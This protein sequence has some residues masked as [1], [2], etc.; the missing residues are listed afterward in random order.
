MKILNVNMSLDPVAGAGTAERTFQMSRYLA[1]AGMDCTILTMD[2][3]M[4]LE[5]RQSLDPVRV[6]ALPVLS[7]RF[8]IPWVR[9]G[10]VMELVGDTDIVHLMNHWTLLNALVY[11]A[12]RRAGVLHGRSRQH[13]RRRHGKPERGDEISAGHGTRSTHGRSFPVAR[14]ETGR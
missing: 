6:V 14:T 3:G 7:R 1:R 9:Y 12:A 8:Y 2:T 5:H 4:T 11:R 10:A 13:G